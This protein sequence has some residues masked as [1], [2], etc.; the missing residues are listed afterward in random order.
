MKSTLAR[1]EYAATL[2]SNAIRR[3]SA[4]TRHE[5]YDAC[6]NM[7][8]DGFPQSVHQYLRPAR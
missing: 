4:Q 7:A 6:R 3:D 5:Q 2:T 1:F 8:F